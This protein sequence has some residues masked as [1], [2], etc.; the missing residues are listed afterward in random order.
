M[1]LLQLPFILA[2]KTFD[3]G[4]SE[5]R[6]AAVSEGCLVFGQLLRGGHIIRVLVTMVTKASQ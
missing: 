5:M 1:K 6:G 2:H 4:Y 3:C